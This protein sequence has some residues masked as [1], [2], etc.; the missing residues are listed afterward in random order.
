METAE[1]FEKSSSKLTL[2]STQ[3]GQ[4]LAFLEIQIIRGRN[5]PRFSDHANGYCCEVTVQGVTQSTGAA[6]PACT[7]RFEHQMN[8]S[9]KELDGDL[10]LRLHSVGIC[11]CG[12]SGD[13]FTCTCDACICPCLTPE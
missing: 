6:G 2:T 11:M 10:V 1:G 12:M 4:C 13:G 7:P 5:M 8:F 3:D 9:L